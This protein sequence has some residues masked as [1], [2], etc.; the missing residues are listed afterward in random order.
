MFFKLI[1]DG[2][3]TSILYDPWFFE[4]PFCKLSTFINVNMPHMLNLDSLLD[5][6]VWK[7]EHL[8]CWFGEPLIDRICALK[9]HPGLDGDRWIW[10]GSSKGDIRPA[11]AYT[12]F[13]DDS[14]YLESAVNW[15]PIWKAKYPPKIKIFA[16]K[17]LHNV[18]PG[19]NLSILVLTPIAF[20]VVVTLTLLNTY[21][22]TASFRLLS[23]LCA[24]LS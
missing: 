21:F 15:N 8:R 24:G 19:L 13:L 4:L 17:L 9:L 18:L 3:S 12:Y 10:L 20:S 16:W 7:V 5:G 23:G 11:S 2:S 14:P 6:E 1:K 22:L